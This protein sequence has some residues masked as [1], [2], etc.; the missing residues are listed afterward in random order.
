M[1]GIVGIL[2]PVVPVETKLLCELRDRLRHRGPDACGE[3]MSPKRKVAFGHRRLS[4][5]DCSEGSSQPM[6]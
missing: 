5:V 3:W 2:S 1:C 6:V 4:I